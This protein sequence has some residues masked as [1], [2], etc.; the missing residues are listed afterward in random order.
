MN[1]VNLLSIGI[2]IGCTSLGVGRIAAEESPPFAVHAGVRFVSASSAEIRWETTK[3]GPCT[4]AYGPSKKLGRFAQSDVNGTSHRVVIDDVQLGQMYW[5]RFGKKQN[6]KMVFSPFY[7]FDASMNYMP[8]TMPSSTT[9]G[10]AAEVMKA[11]VSHLKQNGGFAVLF[12][13]I[14]RAWAESLAAKTTLSVVAAKSD[15]AAVDQLRRDWY[16]RAIYGPRLSSRL[17][18]TL[19]KSFANLIIT[20]LENFKDAAAYVSSSGQIVSVG[21]KPTAPGFEWTE[22]S[23]GVFLGDAI[24]SQA[25]AQWGHQYGSTGNASFSGETLRGVDKASDLA[26]KWIG[27]PGAD[28]GIDRNPRMPA[29]LATG[30]RLFHQGMNRMIALDAY[31]GAVLWSLEIPDLRRVNVPRDSANWCAD[32]D[33]VYA[34]IG[35]RAWLIDAASGQM[36]QTFELP[37]SEDANLDWGYIAVADDVLLGTS[38][39]SGSDY[40]SFWGKASWYDGKDDA[41]TAKVCGQSLIAYEKQYGA[42]K[43]QYPADAIVHSTIAIA[44]GRVYFVKV[45]D[46]SL[47]DQPTGKLENKQI[48]QKA[49]VVCLDL[50]TGQPL[51]EQPVAKQKDQVIVSFGLADASQYLLET[52]GEN[53]F[54]FAAFDA[55]SGKSRWSRSVA[56]PEDNHGGHMQHAVL[57]NDKLFVQPHIIDAKTGAILQS[58]TLG[59]RRGCATPVGAGNFVIYRGGTG[60]LSLWSL[61]DDKP[62]EFARLRPSCWLSTIPAQGMLFSPEGGGGCSCGGWMETSIGFEPNMRAVNRQAKEIR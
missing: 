17:I 18:N 47:K 15:P 11:I 52:S 50:Q 24:E 10:E 36:K 57:M 22:L 27:R 51:W 25:L 5:Y 12:E 20:P 60:P 56:W 44:D 40:D 61:K 32:E 3:A 7:Q 14:D 41:A 55:D 46:P 19:P 45:D 26:M 59:K 54:H 53:E 8:A 58:D 43:W 31:N 9:T 39:K 48:W 16:Q 35:D 6:G 38:M 4:V 49:L 37:D 34:A 29:P 62:T 42:I 23:E 1:P 2:V 21:G 28:F 30:G 33:T 13:S